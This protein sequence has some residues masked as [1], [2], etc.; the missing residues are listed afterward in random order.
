MCVELT[1]RFSFRGNPHAVNADKSNSRCLQ[2]HLAIFYM[3]F[4]CSIHFLDIF[5]I[6]MSGTWKGILWNKNGTYEVNFEMESLEAGN[7]GVGNPG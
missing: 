2:A 4:V 7:M 5:V 6:E 3:F 1:A